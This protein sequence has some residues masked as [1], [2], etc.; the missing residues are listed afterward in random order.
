MDR[1]RVMDDMD[2]FFRLI[3]ATTRSG[4][5]SENSAEDRRE[6]PM[7]TVFSDL[8]GSIL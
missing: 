8:L 1:G 4:D 5:A 2:Q 3:L 6:K 7:L